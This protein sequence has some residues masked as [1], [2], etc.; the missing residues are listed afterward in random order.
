VSAECQPIRKEAAESAP[1]ADFDEAE[2]VAFGDD[3]NRSSQKDC[4]DYGRGSY[5]F[6]RVI[7][8]PRRWELSWVAHL[9]A[10]MTTL[11]A[12]TLFASHTLS[13]KNVIVGVLK[14]ELRR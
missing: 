11:D 10:I 2:L 13:R 7:E 1:D 14:F 4:D 6:G 12:G 5:A 8:S 9:R 3:G